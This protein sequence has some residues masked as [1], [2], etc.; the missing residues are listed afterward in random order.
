M[1][2]IIGSDE[3]MPDILDEVF[4]LKKRQSSIK[5]EQEKKQQ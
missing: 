1:I 4:Q 3:E 2:E 5:E